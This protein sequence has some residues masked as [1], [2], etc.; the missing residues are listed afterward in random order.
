MTEADDFKV[1]QK[2]V[3]DSRFKSE[4]LGGHYFTCALT[5][6]RLDTE[7]TSIVQAARMR[8]H[9]VSGNDDPRNGLA[10]TPDAHWM[11]DNGLWT[12]VPV[13]NDL[14]VQ[15]ATSR[16]TESSPSGRRLATLQGKPS[17]F[18]AHARLRPMIGCLAW[19]ARKH[20]LL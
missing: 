8:Q 7:T 5:G 10:L 17:H 4:V 14:L 18:H 19:H 20:R 13:G 11:F 3:R 2:K 12:A 16:F 1:S 6:Y 9:A 15:V